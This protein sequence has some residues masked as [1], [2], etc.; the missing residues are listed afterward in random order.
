[1]DFPQFIS[2]EIATYPGDSGYYLL[3]LCANGQVADTH[4]ATIEEAFHQADYEFGVK[5]EEWV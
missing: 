4:H 5:P 3:H 1:M 2:L